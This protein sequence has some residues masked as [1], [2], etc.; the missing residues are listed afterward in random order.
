MPVVT[1]RLTRS[2][3]SVSVSKRRILTLMG[4]LKGSPTWVT[5]EVKMLTSL[6]GVLSRAAPIPESRTC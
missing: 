3:V 2:K 4:I 6:S 1:S 5:S